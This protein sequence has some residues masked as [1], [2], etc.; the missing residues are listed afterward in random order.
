MFLAICR[1]QL[2]YGHNMYFHDTATDLYRKSTHVILKTLCFQQSD[3][4][5]EQPLHFLFPKVTSFKT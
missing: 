5:V 2:P 3:A 1:L 4:F